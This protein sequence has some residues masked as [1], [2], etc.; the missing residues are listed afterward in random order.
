MV[1]LANLYEGSAVAYCLAFAGLR[2][3]NNK[4]FTEPDQ[5]IRLPRLSNRPA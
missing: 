3:E 1:L 5:W 2:P 4:A